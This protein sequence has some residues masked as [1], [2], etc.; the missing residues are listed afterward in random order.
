MP[1]EKIRLFIRAIRGRN[2][3]SPGCTRF[4]PDTNLSILNLAYTL[5]L[6]PYA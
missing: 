3:K 1:T 6:K 5:R 2:K 4:K